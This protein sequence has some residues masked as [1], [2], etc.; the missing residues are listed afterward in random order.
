[1]REVSVRGLCERD[2]CE[3]SIWE[4]KR[5]IAVE[6][7][8]GDTLEREPVET[9]TVERHVADIRKQHVTWEIRRRAIILIL[10]G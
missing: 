2:L 4:S 1:M 6:A 5:A 3:R 9:R 8:H 10:Q 7:R